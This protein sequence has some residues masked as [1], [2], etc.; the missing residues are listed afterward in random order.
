MF[1]LKH[2]VMLHISGQEH[3]ERVMGTQKRTLVRSGSDQ[4]QRGKQKFAFNLCFKSPGVSMGLDCDSYMQSGR[5]STPECVHSN[6]VRIIF[7]HVPIDKSEFSGNF[8]TFLFGLW[9]SS[10]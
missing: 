7:R 8:F 6:F 10:V 9:R 3:C 2:Y 5:R 4:S 1:I